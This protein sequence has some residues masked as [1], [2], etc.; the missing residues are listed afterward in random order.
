M[1]DGAETLPD[2][3]R[4]RLSLEKL[5]GES[6]AMRRTSRS[7]PELKSAL[8]PEARLTQALGS[9]QSAAPAARRYLAER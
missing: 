9:S 1:A 5:S 4:R 3:N 8:S 2:L 7:L 6:A